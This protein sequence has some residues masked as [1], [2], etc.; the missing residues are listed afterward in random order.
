MATEPAPVAI[1]S[2]SLAD[3]LGGTGTALGREITFPVEPM[4]EVTGTV[5]VVGVVENVAYDGLAEQGTR[6][7]IRYT[8]GA[9][10]RA[11]RRDVY[12]PLSQYAV[13]TVSFAA[14]SSGPPASLIDPIR[15][16]IAQVAPTSAVHWTSALNDAVAFE[17]APARFYGVLIAMFSSSAM[18]LTG[19]GL[20]ALLWND[21]AR[22]TGEMG[23]RFALGASRRQVAVL[24][25]STAAKPVALGSAVGLLGALWIAD[26]VESLLYDVPPFDLVSFGVAFALLTSVALVAATV[27]ARRA[28]SVDPM[29]ALRSE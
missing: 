9:D 18:L 15:H 20:F 7:V 17:Y 23:L 5:R 10:P 2:R 22:R 24:M 28:A 12:V 3:R 26:A 29:V 13:G 16:S 19:A 1:I 14:A 8:D 27:P 25:L 6:R 21:V 11:G 4:A